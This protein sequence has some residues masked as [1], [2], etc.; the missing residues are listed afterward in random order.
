VLKS[1][2]PPRTRANLHGVMSALSAWLPV[3]LCA[4]LIWALGGDSFAHS[5]TSRIIGPMLRWLFPDI[6]PEQMATALYWIRKPM[7]P[8]EYGLLA[9]L[10]WRASALTWPLDRRR[11]AIIAL[12]LAT[13]LAIG[14]ELRQSLLPTR[15]GSGLDS[16]LDV[17]GAAAALLGLFA[18]ERWLGRPLFGPPAPP[19][20]PLEGPR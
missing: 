2:V 20:P 14:D 8:A 15:T 12:G 9:A 17:A 1:P 10:T 5:E 7:H 16:M 4:A 13:A 11:W 18:L 6:S 3:A 19:S